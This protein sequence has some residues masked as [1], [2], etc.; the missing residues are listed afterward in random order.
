MTAARHRD[1]G[2]SAALLVSLVLFGVFRNRYTIGTPA[3]TLTFG[4]LIAIAF[5]LSLFSTIAGERKQ[6]RWVISVARSFWPPRS[7]CL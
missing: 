7:R 2:E 3:V 5:L 6:T 4:V 1:W